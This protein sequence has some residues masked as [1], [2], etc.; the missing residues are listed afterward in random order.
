M[1]QEG[2]SGTPFATVELNQANSFTYTWATPTLPAYLVTA[3]GDYVL[4]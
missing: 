3:N 1:V 2:T 4:D